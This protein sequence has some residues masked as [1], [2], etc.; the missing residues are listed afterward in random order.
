MNKANTAIKSVAIALRPKIVHELITILPNLTTWLTRRKVKIYFLDRDKQRVAKIYRQLPK[1]I[2]FLLEHDIAKLTDLVITLGGDGTI[3]GMARISSSSFPPIFGINLGM[4]GFIAEFSKHNFYDG[5]E[6]TIKGH[7]ET[8]KVPLFKAVLQKR[9]NIKYSGHFLND[10]VIS[11]NKIS[12]MLS[13]SVETEEQLIYN[14]SGDGLI[15]SSP[16]G[17]TAYSLAAG[18]PI[19]HPGVRGMLLT[20][21]CPHGLTTRPI[22]IPEKTKLLVRFPN[23]NSDDITLTLDGQEAIAVQHTDKITISK[24]TSKC[25]FLVKNMEKK[26]FQTLVDKFRYGTRN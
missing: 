8:Q 23:E 5:L 11:K 24:G 18:G 25:I 1:N 10:A 13:L 7:F 16:M 21:I 4:L 22:V 17:S 19:L 6:E 12:R 3:I 14:T 2:F 15:I 26:Y 20:P 9:N